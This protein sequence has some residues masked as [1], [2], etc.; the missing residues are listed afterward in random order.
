VGEVITGT[1]EATGVAFVV[2]VTE[3]LKKPIEVQV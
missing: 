2:T 1:G 3:V